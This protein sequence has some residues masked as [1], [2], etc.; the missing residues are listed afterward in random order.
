MWCGDAGPSWVPRGCWVWLLVWQENLGSSQPFKEQSGQTPRLPNLPQTS[1][2]W[3]HWWGWGPS[4][5]SGTGLRCWVV[6]P[7]WVPWADTVTRGP[8][9]CH[10]RRGWPLRG[11]RTW[12]VLSHL[13]DSLS[14]PSCQTSSPQQTPTTPL[15][16][17]PRTPNRRRRHNNN[18]RRPSSRSSRQHS[19]HHQNN[20]HSPKTNHQQQLRPA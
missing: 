17:R 1:P 12:G 15:R 14:R 10:G 13:R 4:K 16:P 5:C 8:C 20:Q 18:R 6:G 11:K 3:T 2:W 9:G 19:Q 7:L